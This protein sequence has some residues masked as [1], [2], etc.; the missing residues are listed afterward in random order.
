MPIHVVLASLKILSTYINLT[1]DNM[2]KHCDTCRKLGHE[3][4]EEGCPGPCWHCGA[5]K[6]HPGAKCALG[7]RSNAYHLQ[8]K[9]DDPMEDGKIYQA[10]LLQMMQELAEEQVYVEVLKAARDEAEKEMTREKKKANKKARN[11]A[12]KARRNEK[13]AAEKQS[14][15]EKSEKSAQEEQQQP[16]QP[17]QQQQQQ[18][19]QHRNLYGPD[20][21]D[22]HPGFVGTARKHEKTRARK[23]ANAEEAD[24]GNG[25]EQGF[26]Q[27]SKNNVTEAYPVLLIRNEVEGSASSQLNLSLPHFHRYPPPPQ[28]RARSCFIDYPSP[29]RARSYLIGHPLL[30]EHKHKHE[31]DSTEVT[32]LYYT[33]KSTSTILLHQLRFTSTSTIL[34]YRPPFTTRAQARARSY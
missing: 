33:G 16:M 24:A 26:E 6:G 10:K 30:H 3:W 7:D 21:L 5:L 13:R 28:A 23:E 22:K 4:W 15:K 34:P 17:T 18:P 11:T 2:M 8:E 19:Q 29:P 25:T 12:A 14:E 20:G 31:R 32:T 1:N 9:P 27:K